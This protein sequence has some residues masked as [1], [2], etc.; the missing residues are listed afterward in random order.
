MTQNRTLYLKCDIMNISHKTAR[1][2]TR[3]F[4]TF[5]F[6]RQFHF[7]ID[8]PLEVRAFLLPDVVDVVSLHIRV[9]Q[10]NKEQHPGP[11]QQHWGHTNQTYLH[12]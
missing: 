3:R 9:S 6:C 7:N 12:V 4:S 5:Q 8:K 11:G 2:V 1:K 10:V